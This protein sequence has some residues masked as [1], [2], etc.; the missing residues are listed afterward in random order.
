MK[1]GYKQT[2]AGVIPEGWGDRFCLT[3]SQREAAGTPW[4][5]PDNLT[6]GVDGDPNAIQLPRTLAKRLLPDLSDSQWE[7]C[8]PAAAG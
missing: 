6:L 7:L 8:C 5:F 4:P 2:E 1:A 3:Q